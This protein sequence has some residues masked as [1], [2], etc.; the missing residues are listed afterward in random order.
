MYNSLMIKYIDFSVQ[1][2][3]NIEQCARLF[4][5]RGGAYAGF[6]HV[7][8]EWLPPVALIV[9]YKEESHSWTMALARALQENLSSCVS[10]QVQYRCRPKAPIEVVLGDE[11]SGLV[12]DEC[13]L[14]FHIQLGRSQNIGL[15]LD[16]RNGR[17]WVRNAVAGKNVLNLFAYTCA[18]SVAAIAGDARQVVNLDLSKA[19]LS[20]GRENHRLNGHDTSN[21]IFQGVD[22]FKSFSRIKKY[23]PYDLLICDPPDL[24]KGSVNAERDYKK[25]LRRVPEL[26]S[27]GG[28]LMLCLNSYRLDEVFLHSLVR[29]F[30]PGYYFIEVVKPPVVFVDAIAESG[31]KV[32]IFKDSQ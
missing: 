4:H 24:Q 14:K 29:D 31:L 30:C 11:I 22:I 12:V 3:N 8:I 21:V 25:I 9:L 20:R 6:E 19:S 1:K 5:G 26:M 13:G 15:F 27:S 10:V 2:I 32:L 28:Q 7:V 17:K 23:A 18:F 16:M